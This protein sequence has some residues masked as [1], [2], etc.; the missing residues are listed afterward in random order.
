MLNHHF[1]STVFLFAFN[2]HF[3]SF[4][5]IEQESNTEEWHLRWFSIFINWIWTI[6]FCIKS[7]LIFLFDIF[8]N[9]I[10]RFTE[11]IRSCHVISMVQYKFYRIFIFFSVLDIFCLVNLKS[12]WKHVDG[13]CWNANFLIYSI[14]SKVEIWFSRWKLL[15]THWIC[16]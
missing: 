7:M 12:H 3:V 15:F 11:N 5:W 16:R 14:K 8:F 10:N 2:L 6:R 13:R 1:I 9:E 4:Q